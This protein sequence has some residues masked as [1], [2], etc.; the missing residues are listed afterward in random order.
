MVY[1]SQLAIVELAWPV[2]ATVHYSLSIYIY[3]Y[4]RRKSPKPNTVDV[5]IFTL[6]SDLGCLPTLIQ[7]FSSIFS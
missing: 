7:Q 2:G 6:L 3:I 4:R 1:A 5:G